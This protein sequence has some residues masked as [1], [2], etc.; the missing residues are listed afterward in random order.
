MNNY[1]VKP[2][3]KLSGDVL[4][5]GDKSISHRSIIFASL[6]TGKC[7]ISNFLFG[8]DPLRTVA[9]FKKMGVKIERKDDC[10]IVHGTGINGLKE[11]FDVIDAGNSGTTIR[12]LAGIL[13]AQKFNSFVTG[14]KYLRKRPMGRVIK[15]LKMMGGVIF[16]RENDSFPPLAI[17]GK[18]LKGI[19]YELPVASAQ[20]KSA[21]MLASLFS[22]GMTVVT[23]PAKTRDHTERLFKY[24]ELPLKEEGL[25]KTTSPVDTF[26]AR[27]IMVPCDISSASFFIV[28]AL[29]TKNSLIVLKNVGINPTRS[30][31]IDILR[32]M[33][34]SIKIFNKRE[35]SG[36]P[37]ADIEVKSSDIKGIKV[38]KEIIP[39]IIDEIPI[40]A[41]AASYA[42][43][44]TSISGAQ[45]LRIKESDRIRSIVYM[46]KEFNVK[47]SEKE[48]GFEIDGGSPLVTDYKRI[49]SFGD[50]RIAMSA[51]VMALG[52][53]KNVE[54]LDAGCVSTS[55]PDFFKLIGKL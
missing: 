46:L 17:I 23:E 28:A 45:E 27:D 9:A 26:T 2:R 22:K 16:G 44:C 1:L 30:G 14:D 6:A 11:P 55:F 53:K 24:F 20:V 3:R 47:V 19:D 40:L 4:I 48:D 39:N 18:K 7:K 52:C 13:A 12:L 29:V 43:G 15:P 10:L 34:G 5:P 42:K 37:V 33:G 25:K 51:A 32:K 54:V 35:V 50:H 8:E 49:N 31:I 41:V 21:I 38:G 36:E